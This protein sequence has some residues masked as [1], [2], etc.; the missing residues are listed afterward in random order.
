MENA[1]WVDVGDCVYGKAL[2]PLQFCLIGKW[3]TK[4]EP[5]PVAKMME[6]WFR[7]AWCN[8]PKYT[9]VVLDMF[10][11]FCKHNLNASGVKCEI[12]KRETRKFT[13]LKDKIV[14][15]PKSG[16]KVIVDKNRGQNNIMGN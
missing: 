7:D 2:G 4:P 11:V 13:R 16:L 3:K 14:I 5:Y 6:V 12:Q 9:L 10:R 15:C 8:T 1:V